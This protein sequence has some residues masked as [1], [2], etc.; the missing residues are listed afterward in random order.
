MHVVIVDG[1]T[2][3]RRQ[4]ELFAAKIIGPEKV[5]I[6]SFDKVD[7][8]RNYLTE[9]LVDLVLLDPEVNGQDG[10][11][12][13]K[14]HAA[15][16]YHTIMVSRNDSQALNAFEY[17]VLDFVKKPCTEERIA[18][19]F[20]RFMDC[21]LRSYYGCRFLS[22]KKAGSLE[23]VPVA[24]IAFAKA[25]GHYSLL[26]LVYDSDR[27]PISD[28]LLHNKCIEDILHLLP[29]N[30]CRIHRSYIVNMNLVQKI[31]IEPGSRY[32]VLLDCGRRLPIG[33]TRYPYVVQALNSRW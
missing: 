23:L 4:L 24:D 26:C 11:D 32:D 16:A 13:L 18:R 17:G 2:A 20:S 31:L 15:E 29:Q 5:T 27:L 14:E 30:F 6:R 22:I 21:K 33:R 28:T 1:E 9:N 8:A 7:E 3:A 25:E 12:I 10:F 19:A